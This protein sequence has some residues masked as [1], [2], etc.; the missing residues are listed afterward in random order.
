MFCAA[1]RDH[2]GG[3]F[4]PVGPRGKTPTPPGQS[5]DEIYESRTQIFLWPAS[6]L[7]GSIITLDTYPV[8]PRGKRP[9]SLL[10]QTH[11]E[12]CGSRIQIS[13]W[14]SHYLRKVS[15]YWPRIHQSLF[16][17]SGCHAVLLKLPLKSYT[18]RLL[19][20]VH[21]LAHTGTA[22]PTLLNPKLPLQVVF[23][24]VYVGFAI[25]YTR[26]SPLGLLV[27]NSKV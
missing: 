27:P 15:V 26:S 23:L 2:C 24:V 17:V 8:G 4:W 5:H 1:D 12:I 6:L 16:Y 7:C 18:P 21:R 11:E 25:G 19:V 20:D 9:A 14:Q 10:R 3:W 13:L 22:R